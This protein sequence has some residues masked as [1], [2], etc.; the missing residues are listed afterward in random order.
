MKR[1]TSIL[2]VRPCSPIWTARSSS[3]GMPRLVANRFAVPA[4]STASGIFVP[5]STLRQRR[6]VPS[7]PQAKT[8]SAPASSARSTCPGAFLALGTSYQSGSS[9]PASRERA[10]QRRQAVAE[11]LRRVCDDRD[12]HDT[13]W[14]WR[15]ED[16]ATVRAGACGRAATPAARHANSSTSTAPMPISAPAAEVERV[17]HA[18]VHAR[19]G[20]EHRKQERDRPG[21]DAPAALRERRREQQHEAAVDGDRR[22]GV[23]G[24]VARVGRKVLQPR[25][26]RP[27]TRHDERS[28]R[29][30][31]RTRPRARTRRTRRSATCA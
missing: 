6:T 24:R 4:G 22:G 3:D 30:R 26:V 25:D 16:R 28:R 21:R 29:G 5:A 15:E 9:T 31:S 2:R 7:P 13:G 18:A 17:V 12:L 27:V 23:A 1:P 20:D 10:S 8:R 11:R 14:G 19:E